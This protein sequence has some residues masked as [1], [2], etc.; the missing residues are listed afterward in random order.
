MIYIMRID[1]YFKSFIYLEHNLMMKTF[2]RLFLDVYKLWKY[3]KNKKCKTNYF[4]T[5]SF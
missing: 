4:L 3:Y 5:K 1:D 2:I